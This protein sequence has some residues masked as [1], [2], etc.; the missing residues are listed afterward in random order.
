MQ[1]P[2]PAPVL[3]ERF[4]L[5]LIQAPLLDACGSGDVELAHCLAESI[6]VVD[7]LQGGYGEDPRLL[8]SEYRTIGWHA[9]LRACRGGHLAAAQWAFARFELDA[10]PLPRGLATLAFFNACCSGCVPLVEWVDATCALTGLEAFSRQPSPLALV[11]MRNDVPLAQWIVARFKIQA[12]H[13]L[14]DDPFTVA[15]AH[16]ALA[17]AKWAAEHFDLSGPEVPDSEVAFRGNSGCYGPLQVAARGGHLHVVQWLVTA[18]GLGKDLACTGAESPLELACLGR[19]E[20]VTAWLC[21]H[22]GL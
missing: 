21:N 22:F 16:G 8:L 7:R 6:R 2:A 13:N 10:S 9:L 19:H 4:E 11:C 1:N 3:I 14:S 5:T 12:S 18:F 20:N 15:C 17:A